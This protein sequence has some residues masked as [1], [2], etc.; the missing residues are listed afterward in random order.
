MFI[1]K[2]KARELTGEPE[3]P[4]DADPYAS[5]APAPEGTGKSNA[6]EE[7]APA[8]PAGRNAF[9]H[10]PAVWCYGL[11]KLYGQFPALFNV[12]VELPAGTEHVKLF[13]VD[14]TTFMPL[15]RAVKQ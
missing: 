13:L 15:C 14:E 1:T 9:A 7:R 8:S 4:S 10:E 2:K 11:T 6:S 12:S 5:E 3:K